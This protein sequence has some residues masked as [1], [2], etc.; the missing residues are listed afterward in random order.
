ME[1]ER[2]ETKTYD[3]VNDVEV[4]D[5]TNAE[6]FCFDGRMEFILY[7]KH[8]KD[9]GKTLQFFQFFALFATFATKV[10]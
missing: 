10:L 9:T 2:M 1:L 4:M 7:A 8:C 3:V 5:E 6:R